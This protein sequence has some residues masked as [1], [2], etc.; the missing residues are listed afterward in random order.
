MCVHVC[1][2]VCDRFRLIPAIRLLSH[3]VESLIR[4]Y[5]V[6]LSVISFQTCKVDSLS[7]E[8]NKE[9]VYFTVCLTPGFCVSFLCS[10]E[11]RG[12][13]FTVIVA[14]DSMHDF[15]LK[16]IIKALCNFQVR[17]NPVNTHG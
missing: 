12:R 10:E 3:G 4:H 17:K 15:L 5:T 1:V 13:K 7:V 16:K 6:T 9:F 11:V 8:C 14:V 2:C